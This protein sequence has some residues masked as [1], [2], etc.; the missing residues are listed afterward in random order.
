M[1]IFAHVRSLVALACA[2]GL[3]ATSACS[4]SG[5]GPAADEDRL[6]V[7]T[8][9][10]MI[11]DMVSRVGGE[12]IRVT[13]MMGPGVDP[14]LFQPRAADISA[15]R[16]ADVTFYNGLHLEGKLTDV[17]EHVEQGGRPTYALA[18]AVP[19]ERLLTLD[20]DDAANADPHF[21]GDAELWAG[22]VRVVVEGLSKADP[23]HAETYAQRGEALK[24]EYLAM[25][26]WAKVRAVLVPAESRL[27]I[28][29]HDAF[30]YFG[31]AYG[32]EVLGI[33]G[34]STATEAGLADVTRLAD[35]IRQRK[36]KA[37]FVE[38]SVPPDT[39]Q[40]LSRDSGAKIGGELFSDAFGTPGEI[41][42]IN[43]ESYDLGTYTGYIKHNIN[44]SVE[45]LK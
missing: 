42:N 6:K 8:T 2:L 1:K 5:S 36:V 44:T 25:H 37:V 17:L 15:L 22:C 13:G 26:E 30:S 38:S 40:T 32:F 29:S 9:T 19:K 12:H 43:G 7:T 34:I 20:G 28:T 39:I 31:R 35:L 27:L 41:E 45:A 14:H 4:K 18:A 11:T 10:T 3:L 21:W 16:T 33:Q 24:Q 23:E